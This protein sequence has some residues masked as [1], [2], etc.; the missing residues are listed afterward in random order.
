MFT[1]KELENILNDRTHRRY[2][3]ISKETTKS[4]LINE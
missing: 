2:L 1:A 3:I 4:R